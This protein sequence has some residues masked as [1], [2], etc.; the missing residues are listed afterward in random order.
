MADFAQAY[1]IGRDNEG[2]YSNIKGDR[3]GETYAGISRVSFPRWKGWSLIDEY[4]KKY[5]LRQG[6]K[7]SGTWSKAL[8]LEE[9][10]YYFYK[11]NFWENIS[12][13][14]IKDQQIATLI[15]DWTLTSSGAKRKIQKDILK[16]TDDGIFGP[17][18]IRSLNDIITTF[19]AE[20]V[21]NAIKRIRKEYYTSLGQP[22][23]LK[24][25]LN[26]VDRFNYK[27]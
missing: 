9:A 3:G 15:Y 13:E 11:Y 18:T 24:G 8:E 5:G 23:F 16:V 1:L 12:G 6:E 21:F 2:G 19:G 22:Q 14:E 7:I 10:I 25:W 4:K 27:D 17:N 26:R 20:C